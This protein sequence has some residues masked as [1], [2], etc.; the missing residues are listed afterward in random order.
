MRHI[1]HPGQATPERA[2]ALACTVTR[3]RITIGAHK[4]IC[5]ALTEALDEN[6]IESAYVYLKGGAFDP[7]VYV[8]PALSNDGIH[9]AWY[10][11]ERRFDAPSKLNEAALFFGRRDGKPF[12]HCHGL[13]DHPNGEKSGGHLMPF[14]AELA[15]PIEVDVLAIHG[16]IMDQ[17]ED[18]E[19]RFRLFTPVKTEVPSPAGAKRA[20]LCRIKP[21]APIDE[22]VEKITTHSGFVSARL[23]GIGSLVGCDF[24]DGQHMASIAS[25]LYIRDGTVQHGKASLDI[26]VVDTEPK[27]FTGRIVRGANTVCVTFE[28]LIVED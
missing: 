3:H 4:P 6:D 19:T 18:E 12:L 10:S 27:I 25:E 8:Y 15:A 22:I 1:Q 13:W 21:N 24:E 14:D 5:D 16:A 2:S 26:A 20:V 28:L 23:H 17:L 7:L 9:A 11:E